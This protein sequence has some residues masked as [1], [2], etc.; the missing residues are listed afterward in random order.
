MKK[1]NRTFGFS[2][3]SFSLALAASLA[4]P[5]GAQTATFTTQMQVGSRGSQVTMLQQYLASD[6]TLYPSGLVT[7][8]F[9]ALTKQA[10]LNFQVR[11]GISA[12]GRV[13][14]QT[15]AKLNALAGG[16]VIG[17]DFNAPMIS[18]VTVS[19]LNTGVAS[20]SF[21]TDENVSAKV[22][23]STA[24]LVMTEA[25]SNFTEPY[26]SGQVAISDPNTARNTSPIVTLSG[27]SSGVTYYYVVMA[28]D[29][30]GNV[31]VSLPSSFT[32]R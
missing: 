24:P 9:G 18:N 1:F 16:T 17:G 30:A 7:G 22:F 12:V 19:N 31:S 20:V 14:P 5:A 6:P 8:Y 4:L 23:Y 10:V 26:I 29:A 25:Q 2:A 28:K 15:L 21:N 27:L 3:L 32:S 13:G 11:N